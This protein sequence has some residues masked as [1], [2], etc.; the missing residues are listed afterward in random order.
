MIRYVQ[1]QDILK[2]QTEALVTSVTTAG[3]MSQGLASQVVS[4]YPDVEG[5]YKEALASGN[6]AIGKVWSIMPQTA[7]YIVILFPTSPEESR[8]SKL[9]YIKQGM[10]NLKDVV[11]VHGWKSLA[12]PKLGTGVGGLEWEEVQK[13]IVDT[14]LGDG[15]EDVDIYIYE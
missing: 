12:M 5:E 3:T 11:K 10:E 8:K 2:A 15:L 1:N 4:T 9:E 13:V 7:P 6:L 14:L